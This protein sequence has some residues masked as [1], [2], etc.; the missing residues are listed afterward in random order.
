MTTSRIRWS[1]EHGKKREATM[2]IWGSTGRE[3]AIGTTQFYC[4]KC[5]APAWGTQ[6]RASR[7]FTL[8]FIPLFPTSTLGEY[9]RCEHCRGEF[10]NSVL[11]LT[12][13]QVDAALAPWKCGR[14]GNSNPP[15]YQACLSCQEPRVCD[16]E[17]IE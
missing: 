4:P 2:I 10:N 6:V 16:A 8:Y 14:C 1:S 5:R 11:S 3:K 12:R 9:V 13:E 7:Y 15:A 17:V